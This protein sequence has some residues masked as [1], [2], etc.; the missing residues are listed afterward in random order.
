MAEFKADV[1]IDVVCESC[2]KE[3]NVAL[4]TRSHSNFSGK[5]EVERCECEDDKWQKDGIDS[6][7]GEVEEL[8]ENVSRLTGD[9]ER[10]N[11]E[12]L[13]LK[14]RIRELES[15]LEQ[16]KDDALERLEYD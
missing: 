9:I 4:N 5:L 6:R 13:E 11:D 1:S 12:S 8:E 14:E 15:E 2:G 10:F 7:D 3:L 16:H